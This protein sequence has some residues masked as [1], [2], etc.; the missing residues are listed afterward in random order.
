MVRK[1]RPGIR[2]EE[3]IPI[4]DPDDQGTYETWWGRA[5]VHAKIHDPAKPFMLAN[6][7]IGTRLA[8]ALGLPTLP[9]EI[10]R[11]FDGRNCWV[12]PRISES[13]TTSPPPATE[14]QIAAEYPNV[15][16][17]MLAFD[18]WIH[19]VDRTADNVLFDPRLGVWLIDHENSLAEP[20]GRA[21]GRKADQVAETPLASHPFV[22]APLDPDE[23]RFWAG[24][25]QILSKHVIERPLEEA[26]RRGLVTQEQAGWLLKYL[27]A[28]R[29]MIV[30]LI[31][32]TGNVI[33]AVPHVGPGGDDDQ[34]TLL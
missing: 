30:R 9:G 4:E 11:S 23:V 29:T 2:V 5:R 27:L 28:R 8:A 3:F 12:T 6:E 14:A 1:L 16:A 7:L 32:A 22:A 33:K 18:S 31:P 20:D 34:Y 25:I 13:G 21:F 17:G 15:V 10:A 19:N 24:R 26:N